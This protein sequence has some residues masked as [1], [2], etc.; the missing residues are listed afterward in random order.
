MSEA[1]VIQMANEEFKKSHPEGEC[2]VITIMESSDVF[3]AE[4]TP[5]SQD[6][7][8]YNVLFEKFWSSHKGEWIWKITRIN[9][10]PITND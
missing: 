10:K 4:I 8:L 2:K 3:A 5:V 9:D 6:V 7:K 1:E